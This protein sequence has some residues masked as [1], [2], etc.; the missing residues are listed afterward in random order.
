MR[1]TLTRVAGA[2]AACLLA[3]A[4]TGTTSTGDSDTASDGKQS[5]RYLI[6]QQEDAN[7]LEPLRKHIDEWS[8]ESGI[9]VKVETLPLEAMRTVL[10]TQLRSGDGPDVFAWGSG[11]SFGGALAE[12]G[13]VKD[14]TAAYEE[15]DW[16]VYDFAKERV[17][18][19]GKVYGIPGEAETIGLFYNKEIFSELGLE[20]PQSLEDVEAASEAARKAGVTPMAVGDKEGWEGGHLLSM[21]LSSAIGSDGMEALLNGERKWNSPEVVEAL[22]LWKGF[23]E[24]GYLP[25]SPTS[26]DYDTSTSLFYSGK[27]A[28]IPTGSWLVAEIED[29]ADFE[30]GY[31]PFPSSDG[32]GIFTGGLG[33]GPYV[34]ANTDNEDAA[35]EFM[36]FL[37][38]EEH[39]QWVV[40]NL[41]TI[42]PR[43]LDTQGL[44]V[45]PLF[46]QVLQDTAELSGSGDFGLNID[47][48]ATDAF[49]EA[50]W[51]GVQGVLTGQRT[52]EQ[53][54]QSLEAA[55]A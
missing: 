43:E 54:A 8:A 38:S 35:L 19:D 37:A 1:T 27:A 20:E 17:T 30:V 12:A 42:P 13:L 2:A 22:S 5:L 41:A 50:M 6:E 25:E 29:N 21:A 23:D 34:S 10:Q 3:A 11:P 4:C 9:E 15:H 16:Q 7:T 36:D 46:E 14:L 33:S 51:D 49:N 32:P 39:A 52:P 24:K 47:V 26:V 45:S 48:L 40:E 31:V 18:V 28:M 55:R 44:D 53:V